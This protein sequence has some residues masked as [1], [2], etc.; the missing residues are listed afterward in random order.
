M[1]VKSP[2]N[3]LVQACNRLNE[4]LPLCRFYGDGSLLLKD[5]FNKSQT[6]MPEGMR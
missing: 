4:W 3:V 6:E 5:Y 2:E 1:G